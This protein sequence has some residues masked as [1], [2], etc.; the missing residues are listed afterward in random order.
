MENK[1][2]E[3]A[4]KRPLALTIGAAAVTLV[5]ILGV[6]TG[7]SVVTCFN[8][9]DGMGQCLRGR[10]VDVGLIPAPPAAAIADTEAADDAEAVADAATPEETP[11]SDVAV[12]DEPALEVAPPAAAAAETVPSADDVVTAT[13][14]LLRA[15]PDGSV[16]IA[17]SGTPGSE[18]EVFANGEPLGV[19]TVENSGDWVIVPEEP[20]PPGGLEITLGEAGKPGTADE[21]FIVVIDEDKTTQPLVVASTPGEASE[22]LQGLTAPADIAIAQAEAADE[23]SADPAVAG[24]TPDTEAAPEAATATV[25]DAELAVEED[26][27]ETTEAPGS[28]A[29]APET[30][31]AP[32]AVDE[33]AP[34]ATDEDL[35]VAALPEADEPAPA[36][37]TGEPAN[38]TAET[39]PAAN[40]GSEPAIASVEEPAAALEDDRSV[41]TAAPPSEVPNE[42]ETVDAII[43]MLPPTIDAIEKEGDRTFFAG[44]GPEGGTVRLYVDDQFV[45][46]AEVADGRWLVEAGDVL[47]DP[48]QR[49][50]VDL[51]R[52][53]SAEVAARAEVNFV[54]ELPEAEEPIAV[55]QAE[56]EQEPQPAPEAAAD[57]PS[58]TASATSSESTSAT[59]PATPAQ[60]AATP[61]Q[62]AAPAQPETA[63]ANSPAAPAVEP[64]PTSPANQP[65]SA[66]QSTQAAAEP[67]EPASSVGT[68]EPEPVPEPIVTAEA[69]T[70]P[71]DS[72]EPAQTSVPPEPIAETAP[73]NA[74]TASPAPAQAVPAEA[75]PVAEPEPA[76]SPEPAVE[77]QPEAQPQPQAAPQTVA[78]PE[79]E[80][81]TMVAVSLGDPEAQRFASGKAIIRRGDNLW[82]IA[83]RVYG[84]GIKYTTIYDANTGQIRDPDRIYP[85]QVFDLPEELQ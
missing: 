33:A 20:L 77:P 70:P 3:T 31:E 37:E 36:V 54:V 51:L 61:E 76:V 53:G 12:T 15:E 27:G 85:G 84:E 46:D 78:Q 11:A 48:S 35:A 8:S 82:T 39:Q 63:Q 25:P 68:T 42:P 6:L 73:A 44:A 49:V 22:V 32:D 65:Q 2:A 66:G 75:D 34:E 60:P 4:S 38:A 79:P 64:T 13:F 16:V 74:P 17:G 47:D 57:S 28:T 50:R 10:M 21:S 5:V 55:A 23:P 9:P 45:A 19:A 67:D 80:V 71:P 43:D 26:A 83:R 1:L 69:T 29:G 59:E 24:S 18:V 81:P 41:A 40:A 52:E 7:P 14:G 62:P 56:Q 58:S 30:A 72:E